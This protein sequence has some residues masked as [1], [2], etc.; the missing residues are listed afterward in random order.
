MKTT[1]KTVLKG[2]MALTMFICVISGVILMMCES[3]DWE[4]QRMTLLSGFGLF[5]LGV[6]PGAIMSAMETRKEKRASGNFYR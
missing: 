6:L 1:I 3:P 5:I 4:T 2:L